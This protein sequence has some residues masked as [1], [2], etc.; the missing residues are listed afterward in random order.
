MRRLRFLQF[1]VFT[2][3]PFG[4]NQLAVFL[5]GDTLS[6]EKMQA[7]A[8]EMNYSETTFIVPPTDPK[9]LCR[10]RIFTPAAELPFAG[11]PV[12]GTTFA[13][14]HA[15]LIPDDESPVTLQL[16][17]GLVPVELLYE[18]QRVTFVW[19]HQPIPRF[20]TWQGDTDRL[21]SAL[22]LASE[23]F[24]EDLPIERA[25]VGVNH[26]LV[27]IRSLGAISRAR[28]ESDLLEALNL[29]DE[30][31]GCFLFTLDRAEGGAAIHARMFAPAM[32]IG[33]DPAT[34][35]AAGPLGVYLLRHGRLAPDETGQ[36]RTRLEQG[37]EMGRP[38]M[39][40]IAITGSADNVEDVRVGGA[41]VLMIEG[42]LLLP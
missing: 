32:G 38:S 39:L 13:L 22:G 31:P 4:G 26:V 41:S 1:D 34:G 29:P 10:V 11:H 2:R 12:I 7:I 24:A 40:D 3:E 35:S 5:E 36:A 27:P 33:E 19:M 16:G 6:D 28:P 30:H 37:V 9:A 20:E 42:E 17:V 18:D 21:A 15:G 23:D 25:I 14:A 8:R